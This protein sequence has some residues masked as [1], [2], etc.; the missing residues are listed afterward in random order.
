LRPYFDDFVV[1]KGYAFAFDGSILARIDLTDGTRKW[2][3]ERYGQLVLLPDQDVT[4][5]I[6]WQ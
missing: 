5:P 1:Q 4:L 2:K 6:N 3:G